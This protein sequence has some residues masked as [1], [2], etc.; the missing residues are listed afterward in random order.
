MSDMYNA[1]GQFVVSCTN[2]F[3]FLLGRWGID[4][5]LR[6]SVLCCL[7]LRR[8]AEY[9][10]VQYF[11]YYSKFEKLEKKKEGDRISRTERRIQ[12]G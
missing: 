10:R 9:L 1:T 6:Y 5:W 4:V 8:D 11:I 12:Y 3:T 7:H 2:I